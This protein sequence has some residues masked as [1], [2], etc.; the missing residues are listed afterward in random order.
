MCRL[1]KIRRTQRGIRNDC[2]AFVCV[3]ERQ[4]FFVVLFGGFFGFLH[5]AY[6]RNSDAESFYKDLCE[7]PH[8]CIQIT[9]Q[10]K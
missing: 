2:V 1:M 7:L 9:P 5:F 3:Q 10:L 4:H 8:L 6:I